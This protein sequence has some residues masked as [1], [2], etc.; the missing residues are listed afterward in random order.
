MKNIHAKKK[1]KK[2]QDKRTNEGFVAGQKQ[3]PWSNVAAR[4]VVVYRDRYG[5]EPRNSIATNSGR[6]YYSAVKFY[7]ASIY[8]RVRKAA[9]PVPASLRPRLFD[10]DKLLLREKM[11]AAFH[12]LPLSF[13]S[14]SLTGSL[15]RLS[16]SAMN[17]RGRRKERVGQCKRKRDKRGKGWLW[18]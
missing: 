18:A 4:G 6:G 3:I 9:R 16:A 14:V 10:N 8:W 17:A 7:F 15:Q 1:K 12:T 2:I 11:A 13:A 5:A